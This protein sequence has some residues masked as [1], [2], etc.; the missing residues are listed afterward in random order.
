MRRTGDR[1]NC[2]L[3]GL[4]LGPIPIQR[5]ARHAVG[6]P[7]AVVFPG[8]NYRYAAPHNVSYAVENPPLP[9][10]SVAPSPAP[11]PAPTPA[12]AAAPALAPALAHPPA[13]NDVVRQQIGMLTAS[14]NKLR[15]A[16]HQSVARQA[17]QG[18]PDNQHTNGF[19]PAVGAG[20]PGYRPAKPPSK[21]TAAELGK[22][23]GQRMLGI[24]KTEAGRPVVQVAPVEAPVAAAGPVAFM[25]PAQPGAPV[26]GVPPNFPIQRAGGVFPGNWVKFTERAELRRQPEEAVEASL[27]WYGGP[28]IP[29]Y[30]HGRQHGLPHA[31]LPNFASPHV[32]GAGGIS[33]VFPFVRPYQIAAPFAPDALAGAANRRVVNRSRG[34]GPAEFANPY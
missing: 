14:S 6:P 31:G 15:A 10:N 16:A 19:A 25:A 2:R 3:L 5:P 20:L 30:R 21:N 23:A 24:A 29:G 22:G 13:H 28:H 33:N 8:Q 11:A 12:P 9:G 32:I 1:A 27:G 4:L 7:P 34:H 26:A 17:S 18:W